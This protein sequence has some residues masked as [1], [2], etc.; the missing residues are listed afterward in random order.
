MHA[1]APRARVKISTRTFGQPMVQLEL[2][3]YVPEQ[4]ISL[5]RK[6]CD[7][8]IL[9]ILQVQFQLVLCRYRQMCISELLRTVFLFIIF[10]C[11]KRKSVH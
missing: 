8:D 11:M 1:R 2:C 5:H 3:K 7:F 10:T 6:V 9:G 4:S